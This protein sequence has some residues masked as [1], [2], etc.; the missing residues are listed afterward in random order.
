MNL[1][2]DQWTL[3][4]TSPTLLEMQ[5]TGKTRIAYA[6]AASLPG[7]T[8]INLETDEHFILAPGSEPYIYR[9][10]ALGTN[11]YGRNL[12]PGTGQ[13]ALRKAP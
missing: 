13:L 3:I 12:G 2:N 7:P 6:F 1:P 4:A 5:N 10:A 8:D 9:G 11:V